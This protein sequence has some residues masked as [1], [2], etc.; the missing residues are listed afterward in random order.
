MKG[1]RLYRLLSWNQLVQSSL[2]Q[3]LCDVL[4]KQQDFRSLNSTNRDCKLP[5]WEGLAVSILRHVPKG[6][7]VEANG[8]V[9]HRDPLIPI[10]TRDQDCK[11]HAT[12]VLATADWVLNVRDQPVSGP[13]CRRRISCQYPSHDCHGR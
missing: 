1:V 11:Y 5:H 13:V 9:D 7:P 8:G 12:F 4:E 2:K 6:A 3:F 10:M